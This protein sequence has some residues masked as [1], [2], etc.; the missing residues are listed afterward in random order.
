MHCHEVVHPFGVSLV[1]ALSP[2]ELSEFS[3][4]CHM[5]FLGYIVVHIEGEQGE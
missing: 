3:L 2:L 4:G 1:N 5:L